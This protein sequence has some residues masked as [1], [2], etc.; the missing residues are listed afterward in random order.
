MRIKLILIVC[1][2]L[3]FCSTLYAFDIVVRRNN[4]ATEL[5]LIVPES[6][7]VK[8]SKIKNE[9]IINF[10]KPINIS[11]DDSVKD[12]FIKN[13]IGN[14]RRVVIS[15]ADNT[16]I[17]H[18]YVDNGL[19]VVFS[20]TRKINDIKLTSE[21][22]KQLIS[23]IDE[24]DKDPI[25]EK[26]LHQI[27]KLLESGEGAQ[28]L[29][30]V[31]L[32][33]NE[34]VDGYYAEE[35][36]FKLGQIYM[37]MGKES[38]KY[39]MEAAAIFDQF[40]KDYPDNYRV[41]DAMWQAAQARENAGIYYESIFGYRKV[42]DLIPD[43]ETG[44][45]S[46]EHIARIY[47]KIGQYEKSIEIYNEYLK[48][49]KSR[50]PE[51]IGTIGLLYVKQKDFENAFRYFNEIIEKGVDY[52]SLQP[53]ILYAMAE[54][55]EN[56]KKFLDAV[57]IYNKIYNIFPKSNNADMAMYRSGV[58]L[59]QEG[60]SQLSRRLLADC[61]DEYHGKRGS[62]LSALYIAKE[63]ME[64]FSTE[65]W[66]EFLKDVL[67]TDLDI[68]LKTEANLFI[69]K[70]YFREKRFD[71]DLKYMADF[72]RKY[73]DSPLLDQ[74]YDIKQKIYIE[75]ARNVYKSAQLDQADTI[76]KKL[77]EEF[78]TTKYIEEAEQ[79]LENTKFARIERVFNNGMFLETINN[80]EKFYVDTPKIYFNKKWNNLLDK[81]YFEYITKMRNSGDIQVTLIYSRQYLIDIPAGKNVSIIR[82]NLEN[83]IKSEV[84]KMVKD[85][86]FVK[87]VKF[88]E[89]N[90]GWIDRSKNIKLRDTVEGYI[91]YSLYK[92]GET[93]SASKIIK[94]I[95]N[96]QEQSI[97]MVMLLLG[98]TD[99]KFDINTL[100]KE[101]LV[102]VVDELKDTDPGRVL[103]LL[104]K[105]KKDIKLQYKLKYT[106]IQSFSN[107]R[108]LVEIQKFYK[109]IIPLS[110]DVKKVVFDL[111]LRIGIISYD[112]KKYS[113]A[114][115]A[116][117]DYIKYAD[118]DSS[119]LAQ[120]MYTKG[121]ALLKQKKNSAAKK[122]FEK[123]VKDYPGTEYSKFAK[124][125]LGD[126]DWNKKLKR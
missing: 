117:D 55:F 28:A 11:I 43:S 122:S 102:F 30:E 109:D 81:A 54:S 4:I 110:G 88:Y 94:N 44:K 121:A 118:K 40:T 115:V 108:R 116:F 60:K 15:L 89:I 91:A 21:I 49:Y 114:V 33:I 123:I 27:D 10:R 95:N 61:K 73:F 23:K 46:L 80:I 53:E 2:L 112:A 29:A 7:I 85:K 57:D 72:E 41:A 66:E 76:V 32:L 65:Y 106:V 52:S 12:R 31:K 13:V 111:F 100:S 9:F 25:A 64:K 3:P 26:K 24:L 75:Q 126:M 97:S 78:P 101:E 20:P 119:G 5:K 17:F 1:T 39:Y 77:I 59:A 105:Y 58:L 98:V 93:E 96:K 79:I 69:I 83:L 19:L 8:Y 18:S 68:N 107:K 84:V 74:V 16:D 38:E 86:S 14:D 22:E 67:T 104:E 92:L 45:M 99:D 48:K 51:I 35:S 71:I 37:S 62:L 50:P 63:D 36:F 90:K 124:S 103:K 6:Q 82:E 56:K 70:S 113:E 87:A 34:Y 125:A 47:N 120:A 42:M